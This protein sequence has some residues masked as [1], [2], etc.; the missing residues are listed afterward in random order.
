MSILSASPPSDERRRNVDGYR[1]G[2]F[3]HHRRVGR[4]ASRIDEPGSD[5][6]RCPA[7]RY[8]GL[9]LVRDH[10]VR[11]FRVKRSRHPGCTIRLVR[12]QTSV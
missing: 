8:R 11:R 10:S 2:R 6:R 4:S 12:R 9:A 3:A 1:T 5:S 7:P